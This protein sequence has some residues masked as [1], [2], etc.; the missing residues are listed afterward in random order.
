[1]TKAEIV[2]A[3]HTHAAEISELEQKYIDCAWTLEQVESEVRKSN[4]IFLAALID[5]N[6]V[7]YV[8]GEIAADE[9]ELGNIA[10]DANYRRRGI[11]KELLSEFVMRARQSGVKRIF[12]LVSSENSAAI[13][14]YRL[15][16]FSERG[17][18]KGYYG[19][20]DAVIM[21]LDV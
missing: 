7:G 3:D 21:E 18:R 6:V 2:D 12:L 4:V 10:V 14:L 17:R 11:A 9:I 16:G 20:S 8:S 5:G 13:G 1:M 19:N 15:V